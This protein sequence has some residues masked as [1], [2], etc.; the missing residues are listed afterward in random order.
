[1]SKPEKIKIDDV[2]YV[3]ADST[4]S[5]PLELNGLKYAIVRSRDQGVMAGFV[6]A[7]DGRHVTLLKARQLWRWSSRFV[8]VDLAE[9]GP[10]AKWE[11]KFSCEL[12]QPLEMLE[13]CAIVYCTIEAAQAIRDVKAVENA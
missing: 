7:I 8:L 4:R 2:E 12:S 5:E 11:S 10:T 1:M 6:Q 13:A 9:Y 3:R